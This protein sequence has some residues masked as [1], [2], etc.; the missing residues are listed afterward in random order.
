MIVFIIILMWFSNVSFYWLGRAYGQEKESL[1]SLKEKISEDIDVVFPKPGQPS[2][3]VI[4]YL[5][6]EKENYVGS[7]REKIDKQAEELAR[8]F[9]PG[10]TPKV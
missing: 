6:P 2:P 10:I 7:E 3:G 8:R 9:G 5:A 1:K 4:D